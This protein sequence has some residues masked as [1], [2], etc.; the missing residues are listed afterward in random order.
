[1]IL[2]LCDTDEVGD[3]VLARALQPEIKPIDRWDLVRDAFGARQLD[4]AAHQGA[5]QLDRGGT[6]RRAARR[7]LAEARRPRAHRGH[8]TQQAR[9]DP[10]GHRG[11]RRRG[12]RRGRAARSGP[13]TPARSP[14]SSHSRTASGQA[15][16][17]GSPGP[18][19]ASP[20]SCSAWRQPTGSPTRCRSGSWPPPSTARDPRSAPHRREPR[21]S[22]SQK[23]R[24]RS[25]PRASEPRNVTLVASPMAP[26]NC[27]PSV[28]RC[29]PL[30]RRPNHWSPGGPITG[31]RRTRPHS[32]SVPSVSSAS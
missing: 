20:A 4:P 23:A 7:R 22:S 31:M 13:R 27:M 32:A 14:A 9:R 21:A 25:S 24:K 26:R 6:A 10:A 15:S 29:G 17:A 1:M 3:S 2:T 8:R 28:R 12:G 5:Q 30:A 11:R 16:S 18:S 19:A